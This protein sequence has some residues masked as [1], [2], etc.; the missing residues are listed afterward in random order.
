MTALRLYQGGYFKTLLS[1]EQAGGQ[2]AILDLVLPKG[3]EPPP[4]IH[5]HEDEVFYVLEGELE[6]SIDGKSSVLRVGDSC[7]A[8]RN[9]RH[10]FRIRTDSV[11]MLNIMTPGALWNYFMEFSEPTSAGPTIS[12]PKQR[13]PEELK[14]MG[15]RLFL[16]FGIAMVAP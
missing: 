3:A 7:F 11:R 14:K 4:H 16:G 10:H 12:Q 9:F 8:P 1:P 15:E 13:S 6:V 5:R 2:M